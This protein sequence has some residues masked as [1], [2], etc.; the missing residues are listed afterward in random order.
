MTISYKDNFCD[1][2]RIEH[3]GISEKHIEFGD[4]T[5]SHY[6]LPLQTEK[7]DPFDQPIALRNGNYL[8]FNGEIFNYP[9]K[10]KNDVEFLVDYFSVPFWENRIGS[11]SYNEWDGFWA[12]CIITPDK[13]YAFT[14]P[15]GKKQL[16][17]KNGCISS[18]IKPLLKSDSREPLFS[19]D[20]IQSTPLTPFKGVLRVLPNKL[21]IFEG[22]EVKVRPEE[23]YDLDR[24][25]SPE[26]ATL[27]EHLHES[28]KRR[29]VN[30]LDS[31]TLFVSGGL[32]STII[33]YHLCKMGVERDFQLL[34]I[35]NSEDEKYISV[36]EK[37]FGVSIE[38]I[39]GGPL[40]YPDLTKVI[41][42]Y[43]HPLERGSL[44][45]QYHLCSKSRGSV[46]Y[47]GDGA[48]EL[49][50]GYRRALVQDTQF[51][52]VFVEIPYYHN[53]RLDRVSMLFTKE[54]RSP[55]LGHEVV[56]FAL[57]LPYEDRI[58]KKIL[59]EIYK[60]KIPQEIIDRKKT[61][62]RDERMFLDRKGY[63]EEFKRM[64]NK[65]KF[66]P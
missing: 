20:E 60:G 43:E 26:W 56:R 4:Y 52:D 63:I 66:I 5:L 6:K 31:N 27:E 54:L 32:D 13:V 51:F 33:L 28:I 46:L 1:P 30:R 10:Y 59:K 49:F 45:P 40:G 38:R 36:L 24:F 44:F 48:D 21:H 23:L 15:L 11:K 37:F 12:I 7:G 50:S 41:S 42:G 16:Y 8:L 58:G 22:T 25:P 47:S 14:D 39:P 34:T 53:L 61:P 19:F 9:E 18:E 62:L 29:M 2:S 57:N 64:F 35:Q 17:Y 3:R 65:T 55:F